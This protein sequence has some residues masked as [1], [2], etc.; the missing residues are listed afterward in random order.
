M[1]QKALVFDIETNGYNELKINQKG[2]VITECDTVHCLVVVDLNTR[3]EHVF[4]PHQ[5]QDG[6]DFLA[7]G[8]VLIGHNIINYDLPVLKRLYNAEALEDKKVIDTMLMAMLLYPDRQNNEAKGYSLK[9]LSE[10]F[11]LDN[12][13]SEYE[14]SWENFNA[15]MLKYCIQDVKTNADLFNVLTEKC[16]HVPANVMKFEHDFAKI[17][18]DQTSRGWWYDFKMGEQVLFKLLSDKRGIEDELRKIFPDK[19]EYLKSVAY[20]VDP[21]TNIQYLTKGEVKGKGSSVIKERLVKGPNKYKLIPFNPG[22][23][24]QIVERFQEKYTWEPKYNPETGNPVCDVQVLKELEFPEAKLLLEYRDLDKLRGQVE[25]W[26]LRAQYSRDNRIH[27]SLNTLGTVTGR[28]SA[29]QPNIQQVSSNK[30]ARSLWG[31]SPGMVQVGSDL[32]GLELRCL[33]H[34]MHPNDGGQ[35]A[36]I[37]LNDD[38]HTINQ[39][40]AGLDTRNQAKVF[41]YALI[42]GA[43]NTKIGSIING[44]AKQ[45]GQMKDRF[46]EN[47]PALKKLIDNVTTQ[48]GRQGNI[49]LLDGRVVPVRS[50]HK[51]LNVLL[52]G[53]GAIVSKMWCI[54]AN[55]MI[56]EAGLPAYQIGFIHDEMQWEC[57]EKYAEEV[58]KILVDAAE[59]AGRLLN[60]RM[61]IAA[62]ATVGK[63]WSECH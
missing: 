21:E 35:Y 48:A 42:Y 39:K 59:E 36:H 37:I 11:G 4:Y 13:K 8:D 18:A 46:F 31:P 45:G 51:A 6:I 23:S 32:S 7:T 19:K 1:K 47:I 17:I 2:Q 40:A 27:G 49:R 56:K 12:Q 30:E 44:S 14:G 16:K 41:I 54:T 10:A 61:P 57:H 62:E 20:Y 22:S 5:I 50:V 60:I 33:A 63:N 34:Y 55:R 58:S 15:S 29:S 38:I 53:A 26:N 28:T 9:A 52:Q 24:Q 25:D 43:G 3:T